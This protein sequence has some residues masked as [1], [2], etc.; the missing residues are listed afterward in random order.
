MIMD[1]EKDVEMQRF[2][3]TIIG[4]QPEMEEIDFSS[5][6]DLELGRWELPTSEI[7]V[8]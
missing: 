8:S 6:L 7:G 4:V 2:L 5:A 1:W 3:D